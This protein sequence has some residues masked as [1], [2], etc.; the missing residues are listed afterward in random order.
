MIPKNWNKEAHNLWEKNEKQAAINILLAQ[1]NQFGTQKPR[2]L[3]L[4]FSYYL[5]LLGDYGTAADV[6]RLAHS[7]QPD[8]NE[9]LQNLVATLSRAGFYNDALIYAQQLLK[10]DPNNFLNYD[11]L[12]KIYAHLERYDE[13]SAAGTQ[14]L[15]IKDRIFGN[16]PTDWQLPNLNIKTELK[17]KKKVISFSLFGNNPSYL[18]G[19]LLNLLLAP[20]IYP[21]WEIWFWLDDTVPQEFQD[22]MTELGAII[23][24][25]PINQPILQKLSWRFLAS[26][27]KEIGYFLVRDVDSVVNIREAFAVNEWIK[28][29]KY[30][31]IM[32][33]WWTHTDLIL[34]GM[35]GGVAGL[36]PNIQQA[37]SNYRPEAVETPNID[38]WFLRDYIWKYAKTSIYIHDRCFQFMTPH[39]WPSALAPNGTNHVGMDETVQLSPYLSSLLQ[40]WE[41]KYPCLQ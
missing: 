39:S 19:A 38:Q 2:D 29:G 34:A 25:Q 10:Q 1:I 26:D 23:K 27:D 21:D 13:A 4:Q 32:R 40:D 20:R 7:Q 11:G 37:L 36:L 16:T 41:K 6:L 22:L 33:D 31:H 28:S 12:S 8:D 15:I 14:S 35:W 30:F 24:K 5:F 3:T 18:K 9:I 17:N